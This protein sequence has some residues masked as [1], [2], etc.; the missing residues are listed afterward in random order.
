MS[1]PTI[2][3]L[4]L[5]IP[6]AGPV[7]YAALAAHVLA[8]LTCVVTGALAATAPKRAG[9]HPLSGTIY[10]RGLG[11]VF[12][13]ASIMTAIRFEANWRIFLVGT[14]AFTAGTMGFLARRLRWRAT[15]ANCAD[16]T[17]RTRRLATRCASAR[18]S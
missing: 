2:T 12:G 1:G 7:F 4:G 6:A 10:Y 11:V 15:G 8:G 16:L 5:E 14:V 9:R 3:I 17:G 13:S 18:Y